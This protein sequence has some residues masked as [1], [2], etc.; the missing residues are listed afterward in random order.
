MCIDHLAT[1]ALQSMNSYY[2]LQAFSSQDARPTSTQNQQ[3]GQRLASPTT[4]PNG[5]V[6]DVSDKFSNQTITDESPIAAIMQNSSYSTSVCEQSVVSM[7]DERASLNEGFIVTDREEVDVSFMMSEPDI[8]RL[9]YEGEYVSLDS[10]ARQTVSDTSVCVLDR[11]RNHNR[12]YSADNTLDGSLKKSSLRRGQPN[13]VK[14]GLCHGS[15]RE[16]Q[17]L[18]RSFGLDKSDIG[19][20]IPVSVANMSGADVIDLDQS[21][22]SFDSGNIPSETVSCASL[23]VVSTA[24]SGSPGSVSQISVNKINASNRDIEPMEIDTGPSISLIKDNRNDELSKFEVSENLKNAENNENKDLAVKDG[25][26]KKL[27][28]Q[29]Y[30]SVDSLF[31]EASTCSP[32]QRIQREMTRSISN[33]SGKGSICDESLADSANNT[34]LESDAFVAE[35]KQSES[36]IKSESK[37]TVETETTCIPEKGVSKSENTD[38]NVANDEKSETQEQTTEEKPPLPQKSRST[39]DLQQEVRTPT[40]ARSKSLLDNTVSKRNNGGKPNLKIS[41]ETHKLLARAGYIREPKMEKPKDLKEEDFTFS[42]NVKF[43]L[44][45]QAEIVN[46][47][48]ESLI[49]LQKNKAG[50][51]KNNVR[52]IDKISEETEDLAEKY[53]SPYRFPNSTSRKRGMSPLKVPIGLSRSNTSFGEEKLS[54]GTAKLPISTQ[55]IKPSDMVAQKGQEM[56]TSLNKSSSLK[57][58]PSIYYAKREAEDTVN[59]KMNLDK[60]NVIIE[61]DDENLDKANK[62][63]VKNGNEKESMETHIALNGQKID[64]DASL[65]ETINTVC[66]PMSEKLRENNDRISKSNKENASKIPRKMPDLKPPITTPLT[67]DNMTLRTGSGKTP[68][69]VLKTAKSPRSPV[70]PLKRLGSPASPRCRIGGSPKMLKNRRQLLTAAPSHNEEEIN[71]L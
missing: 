58:K 40:V 64:L 36:D 42:G 22:T 41:A 47:R 31:S 19:Y 4:T 60:S 20:P 18:R 48:R 10:I 35:T 23:D 38:L 15:E 51:V 30:E 13:S 54:L 50:F 29:K 49:A 11:S 61:S 24:N 6:L 55:L 65:L 34:V 26:K 39:Q 3:I 25:E 59:R 53:A 70:K 62:D 7:N 69:E 46:P 1:L 33:D 17:K 37:L 8:S 63:C 5:S 9:R 67:V 57:R 16:V 32:V 66:T 27:I 45:K 52:Q 56:N 68:V 21:I 14:A 43:P 28:D 12:S 71:N 44:I 2:L